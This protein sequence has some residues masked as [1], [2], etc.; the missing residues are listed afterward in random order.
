MQENLYFNRSRDRGQENSLYF[1]RSRGSGQENSLYFNRSKGREQENLY[2]YRSRDRG[3]ENSLYFI[4]SRGRGQENSLYFN[5]SRGRGQENL[6]FYRSRDRGQENLY[7]YQSRGRRQ[8]TEQ[9]QGAGQLFISSFFRTFRVRE[10]NSSSIRSHRLQIWIW[11]Q[12]NFYLLFFFGSIF[13]PSV[14]PG[15]GAV[16]GFRKS[17]YLLVL[18]RR[19]HEK[20]F[21]R[22]YKFRNN[23][24]LQENVL[25]AR[26]FSGSGAFLPIRP[27][28][29]RSRVRL[30][31]NFLSASSFRYRRK[32]LQSKS[33]SSVRFRNMV[34]RQKNLLSNRPT[35]F[36][37][38]VQENNFPSIAF[39][40]P[41]SEAQF[42]RKIFGL[43]IRFGFGSIFYQ[44]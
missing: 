10:I 17:L 18:Q 37:T 43:R 12:K 44:K 40:L 25:S 22:L 6:Y 13:Y 1:I 27:A 8:E 14:L 4:R 26:L 31:Q 19:V 34:R 36:R 9:G 30:Q 35:K 38:M 24:W 2:F 3:Q 32:T 28:R 21:V 33:F 42:K 20:N 39:V 15:S 7:F 16:S 41:G 5:R 29:F 11:V 23:V